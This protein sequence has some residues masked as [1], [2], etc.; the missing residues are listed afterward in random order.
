MLQL[1]ALNESMNEMQDMNN[2]LQRQTNDKSV[3]NEQ[4]NKQ[5]DDAKNKINQ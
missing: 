1:S 4:I 3:Q 5:L 2:S